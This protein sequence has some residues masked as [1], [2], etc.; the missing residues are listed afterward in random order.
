MS[1]F[2]A[3]NEFKPKFFKWLDQPSFVVLFFIF[4][5]L[6]ASVQFYIR[7]EDSF[8]R[9]GDNADANHPN[10]YSEVNF[11]NLSPDHKWNHFSLCGYYLLPSNKIY[12]FL[13]TIFPGYLGNAVLMILQRIIAGLFMYL[14][15]RRTLRLGQIE[16]FSVGLFY[17]FLFAHF[18]LGIYHQLGQPG[19]PMFIYFA[20]ILL[21]EKRK[22]ITI[23]GIVLIALVFANITSLYLSQPFLL[24]FIFLFFVFFK[25]TPLKRLLPIGAI[26]I[27]SYLVFIMPS[28]IESL[29]LKDVS[30]KSLKESQSFQLISISDFKGKGIW[31][32]IRMEYIPLFIVSLAFLTGALRRRL[33]VLS[34]ITLFFCSVVV[35]FFPYFFGEVLKI[36]VT[37]SINIT[38]FHFSSY[39]FLSILIAASVRHL[40]NI[41]STSNAIKQRLI[42]KFLVIV[43][44][45]ITVGFF[46]ISYLLFIRRLPFQVGKPIMID[47]NDLLTIVVVTFVILIGVFIWYI[48]NPEL[49]YKKA[50][51]FL[52]LVMPLYGVTKMLQTGIS[53]LISNQ[54]YSIL[55]NLPTYKRIAPK[56][57]NEPLFRVGSIFPDFLRHPACLTVSGL[58]TVDGRASMYS[59]RYQKYWGEVIE[60]TLRYTKNWHGRKE[61]LRLGSHGSTEQPPDRD[62]SEL[63]NLNLLSLANTKYFFT[64]Y[65]ISDSSLKQLEKKT[66][67]QLYIYENPNVL[68]RFILTH[69]AVVFQDS[70]KLLD[71]LS[72]SSILTLRNIV[73]LEANYLPEFIPETSDSIFL[74]DSIS[75]EIYLSDYIRLNVKSKLNGVLIV[76]NNYSPFW[77]AKVN[78]TL[79]KVVPADFTFQGVAVPAGE[80]VV[81]LVYARDEKD[82]DKIIRRNIEY[83]EKQKNK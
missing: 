16:S 9:V 30:T 10:K 2:N 60:N 29:Q 40:L 78:N 41:I 43:T 44:A 26:F 32:I 80:N 27:V 20:D 64:E 50:I 53:D 34:L 63:F 45:L 57:Q 38:R 56:Q 73:F 4:W 48:R 15:L 75:V 71:S 70:L 61:L 62:F 58:E 79:K 72:N 31:K 7:G 13:Q 51:L 5:G 36:G 3:T 21:H 33:Y 17:P 59:L 14:L 55:Y 69:S 82:I 76:S 54:R 67:E 11:P 23:I 47:Q 49:I 28:V 37:K 39:F 8:I 35:W 6:L 1:N 77:R 42:P 24:F 66:D 52:I 81:E 22:W 74:Q 46:G 25:P 83:A 12:R 68:P 18:E 19:L 65:T